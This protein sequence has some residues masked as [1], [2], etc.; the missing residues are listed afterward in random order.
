[1]NFKFSNLAVAPKQAIIIFDI[2][3]RSVSRFS[4]TKSCTNQNIPKTTEYP[5]SPPSRYRYTAHSLDQHGSNR[6]CEKE[7]HKQ[8]QQQREKAG[9]A[10]LLFQKETDSIHKTVVITIA[11][12]VQT[13]SKAART[14]Y[15]SDAS[16]SDN[17]HHRSSDSRM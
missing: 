11:V 12:R 6:H 14:T 17:F 4:Q 8:Q 1:M 13:G 3:I 2:N 10:I 7:G 5:T 16:N 9:H 15:D